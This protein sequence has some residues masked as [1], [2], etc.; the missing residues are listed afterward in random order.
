MRPP[1]L[2]LPALVLCAGCTNLTPAT[3]ALAGVE[4]ASVA[5]FGRGVLDLGVSAV[6]GKDCS[7]V[8]LDKGQT[9]CA[10]T[11]RPA[12]SPFCTRS[13][14]VVDCWTDPAAL[15]DPTEVGDTPPPTAAQERYRQAR[16]PKA[17]SVGL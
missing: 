4:V 7:I 5:V 13:L 8:R 10:Q 1:I 9:Y 11:D 6:T 3:A 17:F 14:G 2:L 15:R 16:W 12:A